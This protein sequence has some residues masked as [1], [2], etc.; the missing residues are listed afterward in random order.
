MTYWINHARN[1]QVHLCTRYG[2]IVERFDSYEAADAR[3]RELTGRHSR[4]DPLAALK[5]R[6]TKGQRGVV[7]RSLSG[8][9]T[10]LAKPQGV[11]AECVALGLIT[12]EPREAGCYF[13]TTIRGKR[14]IS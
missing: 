10:K 8:L 12:S 13:L 1:G 2:K 3:F 6:I 11:F 7:E 5:L 14:A 9:Q 4:P